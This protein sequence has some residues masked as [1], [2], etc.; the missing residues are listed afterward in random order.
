MSGE[1]SHIYKAVVQFG[2]RR[3]VPRLVE[4]VMD[5]YEA[6][7][8]P[9]SRRTYGTGQRAYGRF[10]RSMNDGE[11]FPFQRRMLG[12]TELNLAFFMAFLLLEPKINK[13]T[14]ILGYETHVNYVFKE[15]GCAKQE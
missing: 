2:E 1:Y 11:Y 8:Q 6:A 9:S 10:I 7:L 14:T 4:V 13:A 3:G 5:L 15:E 12:V